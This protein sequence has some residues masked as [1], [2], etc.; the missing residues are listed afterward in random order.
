MFMECWNTGFSLCYYLKA[1]TQRATKVPQSCTKKN[2][3]QLSLKRYICYF[4]PKGI[5]VTTFDVIETP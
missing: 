3:I 2:L 1:V 4:V 5:K